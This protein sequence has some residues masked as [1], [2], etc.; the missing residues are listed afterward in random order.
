MIV[1]NRREHD[2][3]WRFFFMFMRFEY[4]LKASEYLED[5]NGRARP[6]WNQL[7]RDLEGLF[8]RP[9]TDRLGEAIDYYL[10][11]PPKEQWAERGRLVWRDV[12]RRGRTNADWILLGV[13]RVRNN[14]FHGGK[15]SGPY[16]EN[17]E[18]SAELMEYAMVILESCLIALPDTLGRAYHEGQQQP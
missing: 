12:P 9:T 11:V 8:E 3:A 18:R 1:R 7:V 14:L 16:F 10:Q 13:R 5:P 6:D 15:L 17:P 4:A 2:L